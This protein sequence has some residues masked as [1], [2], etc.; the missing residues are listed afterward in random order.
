MAKTKSNMLL[1]MF[2]CV[3]KINA[4]NVVSPITIYQLTSDKF[5]EFGLTES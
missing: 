5:S 3:I 1:F 2:L 4:R